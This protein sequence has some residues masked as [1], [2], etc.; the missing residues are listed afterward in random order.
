MEALACA[1]PEPAEE[2]GANMDP[3]EVAQICKRAGLGA[4][5]KGGYAARIAADRFA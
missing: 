2:G 5:L 1:S 3:E 4:A